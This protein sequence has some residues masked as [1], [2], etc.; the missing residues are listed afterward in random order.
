MVNGRMIVRSRHML[1][2][3]DKAV[4]AKAE[5]YRAQVSK[6]L[7]GKLAQAEGAC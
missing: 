4:M 1:T 3:D 5:G 6:S 2:V 7:S